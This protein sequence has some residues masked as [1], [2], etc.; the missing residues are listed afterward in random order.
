MFLRTWTVERLPEKE[1]I[2]KRLAAGGILDLDDRG[3][4]K[5]MIR[6]S[7]AVPRGLTNVMGVMAAARG[8]AEDPN[9]VNGATVLAALDEFKAKHLARIDRLEAALDDQAVTLAAA[10]LGGS[11]VTGGPAPDPE[12]TT[13]FASYFRRGDDEAA[14]KAANQTGWRRDAINA[15][16]SVGS[17]T[18]GGYTAPV[19]WDRKIRQAQ[20]VQSPMR[21]LA[22]V[23]TTGVAGY[24]TLWNNGGW[25]SAWVGETASRPTTTAATFSP[26]TF[27]TG[28]IYAEPA[29]TQKLLD[30]SQI[31]MG[32]YLASQLALEFSRQEDIAFVSG[33]GVNK[34]AGFMT[35]VT[36]G[37]NA[38]AHPGGNLDV[39]PSG[40]AASVTYDGLVNMLYGLGAA[41]R[42]NA[43]W[44]MNSTTAAVLMK[45]KDSA[46]FPIWANSMQIDMPPNLL[47]RPVEI[48]E[49]MPN[50]AAGTSPIAL[51]DF[52]QGYVI[53]DRFGV[54]I[55]RDPYTAKPY[56]LF[57][58]TK[59]VGGGLKDPR[60][61]RLMKIA[62]S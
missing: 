34:P 14:V 26:L 23:V 35:Y 3:L 36:G 28:E 59:R 54:R 43:S 11:G 37:A 17:N 30:D 44:T 6:A 31:D 21:R 19:E 56:V 10:K 1:K 12:Y 32:E 9:D 4:A 49:N 55:L 41:Y 60:A 33:D 47:G 42:P 2:M 48:N 53:N 5:G 15:A 51:G 7:A 16:M 62:A 52:Q 57:Y 46:S 24:S 8:G 18:D 38:G 22:E 29:I 13:A 40:D 20:L 27:A 50:L 61:I 45:L 39:V 25:G 58:T